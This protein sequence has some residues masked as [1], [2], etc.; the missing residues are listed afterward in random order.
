LSYGHLLPPAWPLPVAIHFAHRMGALVVLLLVVA[1]VAA[2][3][4][5]HRERPELM[6]PVWALMAIV[7]TQVSLGAAVV[8]SRKPPVINTLH[9][10]TGAL[11]LGTSLILALR[12]HRIRFD[13]VRVAA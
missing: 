12:A 1:N 9:V 10:A 6:R 2:I 5:R 7:A 8:L 11:V 13:G 4:R 3:W